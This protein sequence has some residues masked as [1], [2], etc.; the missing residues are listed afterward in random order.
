M[1]LITPYTERKIYMFEVN[2]Y[3]FHDK[4]LP[5]SFNNTARKIV[6]KKQ[7]NKISGLKEKFITE[8]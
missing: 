4:Q 5:E 6:A 7:M 3:E 1:G 2:T 8:G